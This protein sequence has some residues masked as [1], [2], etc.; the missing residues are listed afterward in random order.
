MPFLFQ[1]FQ[2]RSCNP[3]EDF[4]D[5]LKQVNWYLAKMAYAL[6]FR[7]FCAICQVNILFSCNCRPYKG[8]NIWVHAESCV[9]APTDPITQINKMSSL[10][11]TLICTLPEH[12]ISS[13]KSVES[14]KET[15]GSLMVNMGN[16]ITYI[17]FF[18]I[19]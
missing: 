9:K 16:R 17:Y 3:M 1:C 10:V 2:E 8:K 4:Q 5:A 6:W 7:I 14:Q 19:A 18:D 15:Q 12:F 13:N 11:C